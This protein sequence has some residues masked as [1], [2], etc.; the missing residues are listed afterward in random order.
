MTRI[1]LLAALLLALGAVPASAA[2]PYENPSLPVHKRVDDLLSRMTLEE[3]VGQMTQ[4]ER[5]SSRT[6]TTPAQRDADHHVR[7]RLG[8]VRRRLDARGEHARGLGRHGRHASSARRSRR[9]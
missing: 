3:K 9:G 6:P 5:R 4:T 2:A 7:A 1:L 8:P